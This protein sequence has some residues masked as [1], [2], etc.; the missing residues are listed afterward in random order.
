MNDIFFRV[1]S[2]P[3]YQNLWVIGLIIGLIV[4][5]GVIAV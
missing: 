3:R 2:G 5:Q 1:E 4:L